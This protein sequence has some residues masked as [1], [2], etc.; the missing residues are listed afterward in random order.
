LGIKIFK[1]KKIVLLF[2]VLILMGCQKGE[3]ETM[4][5]ERVEFQTEDNVMLVGDF[6]E[7]GEKGIILLH[8][9]GATRSVWRDFA[10]ELQR[11]GYSVLA[12]DLRGHGESDLN[13]RIFGEKEFNDMILDARAAKRFLSKEQNVVIG[14]S[15]GANTA[16]KFANEVDAAIAL[17]PGLNYRGIN[18]EAAAS[19]VHK[20]VLIIAS[21][22]D[23]YSFESSEKLHTLIKNSE[24]KTYSNK[25]HGTNMLDGET[26]SFIHEWLKENFI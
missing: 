19:S 18:A 13:F 17:S 20:L 25:G 22:E 5:Y 23:T 4:N 1:E 10:Q 21:S 8:I 9:L 2:F 14:A 3:G 24:L 7:G 12:I 16:I 26:K 15:I 6:Y 11:D